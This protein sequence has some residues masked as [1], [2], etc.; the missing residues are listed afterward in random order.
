[1]RPAPWPRCCDRG[2]GEA[3]RLARAPP[4]PKAPSRRRPSALAASPPSIKPN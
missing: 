4:R 1:M 2:V 3:D